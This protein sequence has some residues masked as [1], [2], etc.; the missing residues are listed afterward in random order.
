MARRPSLQPDED[1]DALMDELEEDD[2]VSSRLREERML[3]LQRR[4]VRAP[5][6]TGA[7]G[8]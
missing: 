4:C 8:L 7:P 5:R 1:I 3:E 2:E 6:P